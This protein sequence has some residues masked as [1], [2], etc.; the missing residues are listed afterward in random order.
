[1]KLPQ[2]VL[3]AAANVQPVK[4]EI[5]KEGVLPYSLFFAES[6]GLSLG[7]LFGRKAKSKNK[8]YHEKTPAATLALHWVITN[9]LVMAPVLAIQ[10]KPYNSTAAYSYITTAFVYDINVVYFVILSFGL[11]CLRYTPG[12]HWA[13]KSPLKGLISVTASLVFLIGCL[14]PLICIWIPDPAFPQATRTNY[15]VPWWAGQTLAVCLLLFSFLYW[16]AFRLY[17]RIRSDR[18]GE[19]LYV[20]REPIFKHENGGLTQVY[21]IV[22]LQWRKNIGMALD[23]L[24]ETDDGYRSPTIVSSSPPPNGTGRLSPYVGWESRT[25]SGLGINSTHGIGVQGQRFSLKRK[26]LASEL[27]A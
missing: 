16:V 1:V 8:R 25:S 26:P 11:L 4:Q 10:P 6:Y 9:I 15:L 3:R 18:G 12:V 19:T 2:E 23:E 5:A 27:L 21:E 13:E 22:T 17:I 24:E 20:K 14:F 7:R